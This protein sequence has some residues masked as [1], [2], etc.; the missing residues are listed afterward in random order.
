M[1]ATRVPDLLIFTTVLITDMQMM[2]PKGYLPINNAGQLVDT[3]TCS[4]L[5]TGRCSSVIIT[6]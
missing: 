1:I 5:G 4:P 2:T 6:L 3:N